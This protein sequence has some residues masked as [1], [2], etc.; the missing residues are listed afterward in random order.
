VTRKGDPGERR[1]KANQA[2]AE[3]QKPSEAGV[4]TGADKQPRNLGG[5]QAKK[6]NAQ[7]HEDKG[8]S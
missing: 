1:A 2:R 5:K 4:T 6:A 8:K 7:L 3:G